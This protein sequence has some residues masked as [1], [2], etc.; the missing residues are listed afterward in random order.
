[1]DGPEL[2]QQVHGQFYGCV[3]THNRAADLV[4]AHVPK[5]HI[6]D[7][8]G[9]YTK[10]W[11]DYRRLSPGHSFFL[12]AETYYK[13]FK[14][15]AR[16]MLHHKAATGS[17]LY[18]VGMNQIQFEA[19]DIWDRD[20]GHISGMWNAMLVC[21]ALGIPYSTFCQLGFQISFDTGWKRLPSPAQLYSE[22]LGAKI[23]DEWIA[24]QLERIAIASHPVYSLENYCGLTDQD[25][26]RLYLLDAI[27]SKSA[28]LPALASAVYAKPQLDIA[29]VRPHFPAPLLERARLLA[30]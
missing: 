16:K 11:W 15:W 3:M 30:A 12:F 22:N 19:R 29:F 17:K 10:R 6:R 23:L 5:K 8:A 27:K 20:S 18:I 14:I 4:A 24:L 13:F 1:V 9:V 2:I 21:D 25:D 26:Y 7:V 28:P